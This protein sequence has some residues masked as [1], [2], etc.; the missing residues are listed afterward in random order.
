[1]RKKEAETAA[2]QAT[3]GTTAAAAE[4]ASA[5]GMTAKG[6]QGSA[7]IASKAAALPPHPP[8]HEHVAELTATLQRLQADFDNYKK[9]I[10]KEKQRW[11]QDALRSLVKELLPTLDAFELALKTAGRNGADARRGAGAKGT[12]PA[13]ETETLVKGL[14]LLYAQF[15]S[16]L[17][18]KGLRP[19]EAVGKHIDPYQHEVLLQ[20]QKAGCEDGMIIEELQKGY[21]LGD[22][23]IRTS[24]VRVCKAVQSGQAHARAEEPAGGAAA[25]EADSGAH[26]PDAGR[27]Q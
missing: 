14:E 22:A 4:A 19:I 15:V 6:V 12:A 7:G 20:E 18:A 26:Q 24:K 16:V 23:V 21:L 10:E 17:K 2:A 3:V 9:Y 8:Q 1:M 5:S 13:A 27:V 11:Q 25:R